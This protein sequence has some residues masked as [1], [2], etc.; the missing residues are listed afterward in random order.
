MGAYDFHTQ[1]YGTTADEAFKDAQDQARYDFG[2][3]PYNGTISTVQGF[4]LIPLEE[5]ESV[6][7]WAG[8]VIED[9]RVQKWEN[10]ACVAEPD[11]PIVRGRTL[12]NFAGWAAS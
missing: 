4:V 3:D 5:G 7:E 6:G 10:C 11:E 2:H 8:R 12:W 9:E 1:A